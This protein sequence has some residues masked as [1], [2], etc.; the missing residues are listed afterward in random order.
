APP[1]RRATGSAPTRRPRSW[2]R[3]SRRAGDRRAGPCA[4]AS[5][6][7][8][9]ATT[10]RCSRTPGRRRRSRRGT[11]GCGAA[12]PARSGTS[13]F[14]PA[15]PPGSRGSLLERD[16][17]TLDVEPERAAALGARKPEVAEVVEHAAVL[18]A[19]MVLHEAPHVRL[20]ARVER[21]PGERVEAP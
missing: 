11:D 2:S 14:A 5:P 9:T 21:L 16:A 13:R 12:P 18:A 3:R 8:S 6:P 7:G 19:R 15:R 1:S 4:G 10:P 20:D 17:E